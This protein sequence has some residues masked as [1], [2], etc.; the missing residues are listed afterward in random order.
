MKPLSRS[1]LLLLLLSLLVLPVVVSCDDAGTALAEARSDKERI[2]DPAVAEEQLAEL[3]GGNGAFAFDLY[4]AL[5]GD[6]GNLFFSPYSISAALAMTYAGARGE[7]EQEMAE[8]LHYL[9]PQEQLHP[10]F[11]ALDLELAQRG[12]AQPET[13]RGPFQLDIANSV[14]GQRDYEFL[15]QFLD[16]LAENYG[17]GLRLVDFVGDSEGARELI[18]GWVSDQTEGRIPD[19]IPQGVIDALTRLVLTNAIY[20]NAPWTFPFDKEA[21]QEGTFHLLDGADVQAP[22]M[23]LE[24]TVSYAEVD[25]IRAVGLPYSDGQLSMVVLVPD[26]G[27]F[28]AFES[29]LDAATMDS[30]LDAMEMTPVAL[31]MPKFEFDSSFS[32]GDTLAE[33]GMPSAFDPGAADFSGMDGARDLVI[34]HILHKAFVS[35]D[36]EGT[37][38]AAATAVVVGLTAA[39]SEPVELVVDRPFMFLIRDYPTGAILFLGRVLDPMS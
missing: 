7:T 25:G 23:K 32:L 34:T 5:R 38:A 29:G 4:R 21:T 26:E 17:A 39:P 12:E 1:S 35:A 22:M 37:E 36:E 31:T 18:N 14:W 20:F 15:A 2:A 8:T 9:L 13:E 6:E 33:M 3:V 28:E 24:E 27:Q 10:A 19:L 16:T 11:N 30:V